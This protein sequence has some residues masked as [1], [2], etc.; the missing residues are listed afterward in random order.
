[1]GY[2]DVAEELVW[3]GDDEVQ[4]M[5]RVDLTEERGSNGETL[6]DTDRAGSRGRE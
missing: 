2:G 4:G 3:K 6:L 5:D 1:L